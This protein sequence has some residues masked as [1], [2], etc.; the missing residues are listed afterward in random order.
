MN[1]LLG[2]EEEGDPEDKQALVIVLA[3]PAQRV[4]DL[5]SRVE[6]INLPRFQKT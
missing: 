4:E 6:G 1:F 2:E 3:R 5:K